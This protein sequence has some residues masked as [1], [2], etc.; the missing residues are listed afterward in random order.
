MLSRALYEPLPHACMLAAAITL[1]WHQSPL[2]LA[3][4]LLLF[5]MGARIY[6]M[7][8]ENR[9]TDPARKRKKGR[10][11]KFVYELFP[12]ACLALSVLLLGMSGNGWH[13]MPSLA[14][15]AYGLYVLASRA[16]YRHHQIPTP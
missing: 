12:F 5:F 11:P 1:I 14:L 6:I 13:I 8:S 10:L 4:G 15:M 2:S 3:A 16:N 9:R 7:R